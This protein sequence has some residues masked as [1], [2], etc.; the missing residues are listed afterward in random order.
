MQQSALVS[1]L[2]LGSLMIMAQTKPESQQVPKSNG[3][4]SDWILIAKT[5]PNIHDRHSKRLS[6]TAQWTVLSWEKTFLERIQKKGPKSDKRQLR[7][8]AST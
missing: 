3:E 4:G 6:K 1:V 8:Y 2:V 7:P 5:A